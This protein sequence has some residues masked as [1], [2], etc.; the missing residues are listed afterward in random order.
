MH[1][2][3]LV[4]RDDHALFAGYEAYWRD[5]AARRRNDNYYRSIDGAATRAYFFP[6]KGT[7]ASSDTVNNILAD[8]DCSGGGTIRVAMA[9]WD[10]TRGYLVDQLKRLG[11]QGC[12][13]RVVVGTE[14][15][16]PASLQTKVRQTLGNRAKFAPEGLHSKY[17]IADA[18][19]GS[20][21]RKIVWTG[22]HNYI[23]TNLRENDETILRVED[24]AVFN[25]FMADFDA[26]WAFY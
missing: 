24:P 18:V 6:R 2:N 20:T 7:A 16:T 11:A 14:S 10:S 12:Q 5:L 8:L 4:F 3:M 22:S 26:M 21:R 19:Y 17:L 15:I 9:F 1:N 25:A 23:R 13:V